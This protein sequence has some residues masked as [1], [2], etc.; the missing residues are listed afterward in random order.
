MQKK[1]L[2][3]TIIVLIYLP[4]TIDATVMHVATPTL[5][6][7]L[8]LTANQLLWIID[9]YSLIMAGLILPM[10]ALGDR[11]GFKKLLF[12][13]TAVFGIGSLAAAFSPTAYALIASR[14]V[15]GLGAAM[16][17]PATL[18]GIRNAFTEEKQRNFALGLWS[19]V[20]G[21]GAAFGPLVGG[22]VLEHFHWGAVFLINI[23]IILVVLVMI[24][25][26]IPKQQEKTD[27]PINLGQAL[28]L[29]VAILSLIYS[30][31]SAMYN[32]SVLTVV[33]FVVGISTLIHFI[34][35]QFYI[36]KWF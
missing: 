25:M 36:K 4:V 1:W 16:L 30:I 33:M 21:G 13:G 34:R 18:S 12:I 35:E 11:I 15:L 20:G 17:I 19:T 27:Q 6:E 10:G 7:A 24:V 9:I 26:I 5:S 28:V 14:A 3:L 8:N 32:F 31:K 22:F 23:P 29:V 2:I